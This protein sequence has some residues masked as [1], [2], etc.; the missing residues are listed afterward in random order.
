MPFTPAIIRTA[1]WDV[2]AW[3]KA[4]TVIMMDYA[5][6]PKERR[7]ILHL[8]FSDERVRAAQDDWRNVARYVVGAFRADAARRRRGG[9]PAAVR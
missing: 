8:M 3:N 4:A 5:K 1:T 6:L 9:N 2:V 7:N